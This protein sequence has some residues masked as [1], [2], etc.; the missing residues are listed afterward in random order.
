M[1]RQLSAL[2]LLMALLAGCSSANLL[3]APVGG[4]VPDQPEAA[5][6]YTEKP[7]WATTRFAVAA[8][9]P[10]A[11]QA[12]YQM[13]KLGGSAIDAAIAVQMVLALVEPQSSGIAGGAFLLHF[14]GREIEAFD[15]RE[16]APAGVDS[17]L[18]LAS[19]GQPLAYF[20]AAIGGRA[21]GTPGV[22]PM[23]EMAHRRHGRLS[24]AQLFEPAIALAEN[25]FA[26]S[27]RLH[28]LLTPEVHLKK[29]PVARDYFYD[30]HSRPWP[31]GHW[32]K[33]PE[34]AAVLRRVAAEGSRAVHEGE[35]AQAI[36]NAVQKHPTHPGQLS[37]ADLATYEAKKRVPLCYVYA[38]PGKDVQ[39]CGMPPPSSGA[40]TVGQILG[41]LK[42]TRAA[43][44]VP[45]NGLPGAE[46]LHLYTE[47][48]RLAYADRAQYLADPD[49]VA[50]PADNWMS[51]LEPAYLASRAARIGLQSMQSAKPGQPGGLVSGY[52]PMAEQSEYGTSHISVVDAYGSAI[53]MTTSIQDAWG[54]RIM[55]NRAKGLAG[56]FLL[57]NQLT[58]FSFAPFDLAGK[59][60]ANRVQGGKRP[61]ASMAPT[62]VFDQA[63]GKLIMTTG[64][65][66]GSVIIHYTTKTLYAT[67][68]WGMTVQQSI[69]LPNFGS[70]NGPTMLEEERFPI[71]TVESLRDRGHDV[72]EQPM[73]SGL[74]GIERTPNG[75][76]GGADPRREGTVMGD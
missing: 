62:L 74:Q 24:W 11:T 41:I 54:S 8:A 3:R 56:G 42:N 7:G 13:L 31:V 28:T 45:S 21:V 5:S 22:L 19:N 12:G 58:D 17:G 67:L 4:A 26:V 59:P 66:G 39:I 47:A 72:R 57:N 35:L 27:A 50:P 9:N 10:L 68:H 32:L 75:Y 60:V 33:N 23:L 20:E 69:S 51:L 1:K 15:G 29:D 53:A 16:T 36:V 6:A 2:A 37:L 14:D 65:P 44:L 38:A 18:L 55:V 40:I 49:F 52:A 46:W 63:T 73:T 76:F 30:S 64:S 71:S 61:R 43:S 70:L 48:S 34:L 25:G